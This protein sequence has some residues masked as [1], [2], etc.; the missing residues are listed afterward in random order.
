MSR[1]VPL[2]P[3][4][5]GVF[6]TLWVPWLERMTG[7]P[8]EP[9]DL[10]AVSDP[11][12][13]YIKTGGAVFFAMHEGQPVGVVAV[14]RLSEDVYEFCK[15]VVLDSSR[16]QGIGRALVEDC[17]SFARLQGGRL[18]M[19]QSFERLEVALSLYR[20]MGFVSMDPPDGMLVL[21]RTEVVMG[22]QLDSDRTTQDGR[23]A[24]AA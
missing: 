16:G 14:K 2:G 17:I 10:R 3:E 4:H 21:A 1:I 19:L 24:P 5:D 11:R 6:E 7:R 23:V 8:P 12:A 9:E 13:F 20:R 18:L 22:L 15:L